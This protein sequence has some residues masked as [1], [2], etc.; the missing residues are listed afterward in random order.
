MQNSVWYKYHFGQI[1][2]HKIGNKQG[3]IIDQKLREVPAGIK[4]LYKIKWFEKT[5]LDEWQL[6]DWIMASDEQPESVSYN[7]QRLR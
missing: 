6:E 7:P 2:K 4:R 3:I 1:V 5:V